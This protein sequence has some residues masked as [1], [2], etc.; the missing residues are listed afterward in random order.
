MRDRAD[1]LVAQ[2][3]GQLGVG[4][5]AVDHVQVGA[6]HSAGPDGDE[7][8]TGA[9]LGSRGVGSAQQA[10]RC[11]KQHGSHAAETY[12]PASAL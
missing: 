4:E 12:A 7:N 9:G 8:L 1:D 5:F 10:M 6:A 3:E 11:V 2:D